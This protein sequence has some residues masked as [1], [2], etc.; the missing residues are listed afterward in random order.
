[1]GTITVSG[2]GK[3]YKQY[4]T[5]W[6]RLLEWV[7]PGGKPRH[8]LKWVLRDLGF[9]VQAGESV[10]IVGVNGAGKSTLL[11]MITGTTQPT[12]GSIS[13]QGRVAALLELGMGFHPD[14][15]GLQNAVMAGQLLGYHV[16]EMHR[17]MPA[18]REFAEIGDAIEKEVRT[19]SSGMHVRLAFAV[20]TAA[21]PDILIVDEALAV[22]DAYFQHKCYDRIRE[23]REAGTTLLFVSHDPGAVKSLCSRAI[24]LDCGS[25]VLDGEPEGVL[26]YYNAMLSQ[27]GAPHKS[28]TIQAPDAPPP[29][30]PSHEGDDSVPSRLS[31]IERTEDGG[32]RSGTRDAELLGVTLCNTGGDPAT[33]FVSGAPARLRVDWVSHRPLRGLSV[34]FLLR[35]RLGNDVFGTNTHH[36][37]INLDEA[38]SGKPQRI[39]F[40]VPSL[41]LGP[42]SYSVTVALHAHDTHLASNYDWWDRAAM[43]EVVPDIHFTF[44]GVA[45]LAVRVRAENFAS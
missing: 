9:T 15:T 22:G 25:L 11:K 40:E 39:E 23:F 14:F 5:R 33:I 19:Y 13:V 12:T 35:D 41:A 7:T 28:K 38:P 32:T 36:L 8:S 21:R 4:P 43:L 29:Q 30:Q 20:A 31:H 2:L 10:G 24:L 18:I 42:G 6:S 37:R 3:A 27:H 44:A 17:L 26:D 1:M 45:R 16:D 34:G